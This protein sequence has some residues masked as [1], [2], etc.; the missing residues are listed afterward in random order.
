MSPVLDRRYFY[1]EQYM[2]ADLISEGNRT[3]GR[4]IQNSILTPPSIIHSPQAGTSSL[5]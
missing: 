1:Q 3:S 5:I 2:L 4:Y